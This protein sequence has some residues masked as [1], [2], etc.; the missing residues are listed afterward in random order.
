M[1]SKVQTAEPTAH[2]HAERRIVLLRAGAGV[3]LDAGGRVWTHEARVVH[4]MRELRVV[5]LG[6]LVLCS[7][8]A[9]GQ[10]ATSQVATA[11][12]LRNRLTRYWQPI[13]SIQLLTGQQ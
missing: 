10:V 11:I 13:D 12:R 7:M 8:A 9:M 5:V 6:G 2:I 4:F 3:S 1:Q